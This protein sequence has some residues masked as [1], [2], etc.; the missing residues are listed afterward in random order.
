MSCNKLKVFKAIIIFVLCTNCLIVFAQP[1]KNIDSINNKVMP[2]V[3]VLKDTF[4]K[5]AA[6]DT[7]AIDS[8]I[9][10][11]KFNTTAPIPKR[12]AI[13]ASVAPGLGQIYNKQ[14]WKLPIVYGGIGVGIYFFY[15]TNINYSNFRAA[16]ISRTDNNPATTDNYPN[17]S[18]DAIRSLERSNRV[19]LD[20]IAVYGSL[21][22]GLTIVDALVGAHLKNFDVGK[23]ISFNVTPMPAYNNTVALGLNVK[24]KL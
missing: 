3:I 9:A 6:V 22:Y 16:Y 21:F 20:R 13:L 24:L 10:Y 12:A 14:Y 2:S 15:T 4:A 1:P 7:N 8:A 19:N 18:T 23:D 5:S 11:Y 17:Y